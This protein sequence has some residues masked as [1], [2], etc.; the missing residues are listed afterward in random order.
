MNILELRK[1]RNDYQLMDKSY[2]NRNGSHLALNYEQ[3]VESYRLNDK[4]I[5]YQ[6]LPSS[7]QN[8]TEHYTRNNSIR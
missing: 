6:T 2:F 1:D 8:K 4:Q 5:S 7:D 3:E